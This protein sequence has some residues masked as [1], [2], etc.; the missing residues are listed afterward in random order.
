MSDSDEDGS[1]PPEAQG[2]AVGADDLPQAAGSN[3]PVPQHP[4]WAAA[5]G[6]WRRW[7]ALTSRLM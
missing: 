6:A 2:E 3:A 5:A 7:W 4:V 1:V